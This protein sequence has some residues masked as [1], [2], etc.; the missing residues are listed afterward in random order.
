MQE[1][2]RKPAVRIDDETIQAAIERGRRLRSQAFI[3]A[4]ARLFHP[5]DASEQPAGPVAKAH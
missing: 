2:T 1:S 3:E 5:A 4:V